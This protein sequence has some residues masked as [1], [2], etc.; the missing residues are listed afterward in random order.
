MCFSVECP[1]LDRPASGNVTI[2]TDGTAST[3]VFTCS[4]GYHLVGAESLTC[5]SIG[6]WTDIEPV[7]SKY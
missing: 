5:D 2:S 3:A 6:V 4:D 7:C 1:A